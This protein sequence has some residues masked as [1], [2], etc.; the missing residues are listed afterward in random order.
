LFRSFNQTQQKLLLLLSSV[1]LDV[2]F[3][4]LFLQRKNCR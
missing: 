4:F 1:S 2:G 3:S